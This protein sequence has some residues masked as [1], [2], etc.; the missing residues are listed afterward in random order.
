MG[1][2]W[3]H[4]Q[5]FPK[6]SVSAGRRPNPTFPRGALG[7]L[8]ETA[9]ERIA[10]EEQRDWEVPGCCGKR[11]GLNALGEMEGV[12]VEIFLNVLA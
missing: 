2:G 10:R 11:A 3:E 8:L 6:A 12:R 4:S 1:G 5:A 9:G 7:I